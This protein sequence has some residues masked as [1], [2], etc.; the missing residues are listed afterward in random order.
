MVASRLKDPNGL[1]DG[2]RLAALQE[3]LSSMMTRMVKKPENGGDPFLFSL[4]APKQHYLADDMPGHR[5]DI[6]TKEPTFTTAA[7]DGISYY[8]NP[9]FLEKLDLNEGTFVLA[10]EAMHD[11]LF[12]SERLQHAHPIIRA[13]AVDYVVNTIIV[14]FRK[15]HN[16]NAVNSVNSLWGRNLGTPITLKE[17]L[18]F[19]DG[20]YEM[21]KKP[22][23]WL[24]E[25]TYG[26]S[27]ESIYAEIMKHWDSSPRKCPK[28]SALSLDPK[29]RKPKPGK[30]CPD[31]PK[32]VHEG[33]C[34]DH[35]GAP[36]GQNGSWGM[37]DDFPGSTDV[38]IPSKATK[39]KIQTDLMRAA[40]RARSISRGSVPSEVEDALGRLSK[41][42]LKFT[43]IMMSDCLNKSREDG[44]RNDY[45][46][47]RRRWISAT[48]KQY[49]PHRVTTTLR[50]L[51]LIDTSGSMGDE[52][53]AFGISQLQI[54]A[55][56][57]T[58]GIIVPCDATVKWNSATHVRNVRDLK[59]TKI[60]GRGGTI[61]DEFFRDFRK[62]LGS[63]FGTI[64][65][66]TDGD[67]GIIPMNL[68]PPIPVNWVLT[69]QQPE[70]WNQHF[71][72]TLHL[73]NERP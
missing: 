56:Q 4:T 67:C 61:F 8:W 9:D 65:V 2:K 59:R 57:G 44:A 41:P 32:C 7:T 6:H 52:D 39:S 49:L 53:I 66:C 14:V 73:R 46:R 63:D 50:W 45:K 20:G 15:K 68:R 25:S 48:P 28:C 34:C 71:G 70:T 3:K 23:V 27:P 21:D 54:L 26:R 30:P 36:P 72:R 42:V 60:V 58:E 22:R 5:K 1:V 11:A 24:D 16:S 69:R 13:V 43:D 38:H 47:V 12:H 55:A 35:C 33:G 17:F 51:A 31:R 10:H 37:A 62:Y 19:I 64:S 18:D 40:A 29:T